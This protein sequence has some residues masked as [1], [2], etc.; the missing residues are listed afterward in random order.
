VCNTQDFG[1]AIARPVFVFDCCAAVDPRT[2]A[3][4]VKGAA[5]AGAWACLNHIN[6]LKPGV[7]SVLAAQL[8]VVSQV[9]QSPVHN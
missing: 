5:R 2:T 3:K 9:V 6:C 7:L 8:G 4:V 1:R